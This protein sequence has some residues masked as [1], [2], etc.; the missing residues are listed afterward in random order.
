MRNDSFNLHAIFTSF[1]SERFLVNL[2][3]PS[4]TYNPLSL[5]MTV[6]K[7]RFCCTWLIDVPSF[8]HVYANGSVPFTMHDRLA[9]WPSIKLSGFGMMIVSVRTERYK[10]IINLYQAIEELPKKGSVNDIKGAVLELNLWFL[11]FLFQTRSEFAN[12]NKN[13][14]FLRILSSCRK[15]Q[16]GW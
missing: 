4:Q 16:H 1:C 14:I 8:V 12:K 10:F 15:S 9:G 11:F 6:W 3:S 5:R 7:T 2:F 13:P